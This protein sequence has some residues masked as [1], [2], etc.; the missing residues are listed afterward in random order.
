VEALVTTDGFRIDKRGYLSL[1][2]LI[3]GL[4][5]Q[6]AK[7]MIYHSSLPELLY[8]HHCPDFAKLCRDVLLERL[9]RGSGQSRRIRHQ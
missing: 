5:L 9:D 2:R 8:F 1:F 4:P 6:D 7:V 3:A